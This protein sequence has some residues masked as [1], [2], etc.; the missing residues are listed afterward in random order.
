[1]NHTAQTRKITVRSVQVNHLLRGDPS[2]PT[3]N[4]KEEKDPPQEIWRVRV[5]FREGMRP[6]HR[7]DHICRS[8]QEADE[9]AATY[10]IGT[11]TKSVIQSVWD[12]LG[13]EFLESSIDRGSVFMAGPDGDQSQVYETLLDAGIISEIGIYPSRKVLDF[14]G[15]ERVNELRM[16]YPENWQVAAEFEFCWQNFHHS[17]AV[18]IAAACGFKYDIE[19]D[20]YAAGY[21]LRDL[22]IIVH[23]VEA[24]ATKVQ[25]MR[26]KAGGA[27]GKTS[28]GARNRRR[29]DLLS[30]IEA[31]AERSPDVVRLSPEALV[32]LD[33]EDCEK[34]G[35]S[36][37]SQGKGQAQEYLGEIRRG[38][39][40][41]ELKV[42]YHAIFGVE[43]PKRFP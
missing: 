26:E 40:G 29:S 12:N 24:V 1:M 4:F 20:E 2:F 19:K 14:L 32:S 10:K 42:R 23:G 6:E 31:L 15:K 30:K 17:S 27:G 21:L 5:S 28:T 16:I 36:L 8:R 7:L 35:P 37:W 34:D 43:P 11:E 41:D 25:E 13:L 9:L 22:E 38:E 3:I 39:A 18:F 33:L